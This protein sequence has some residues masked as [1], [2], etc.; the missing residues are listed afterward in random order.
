[1]F[2]GSFDNT[3]WGKMAV[4]N[5]SKCRQEDMLGKQSVNLIVLV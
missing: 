2:L 3:L 5:I 1:M 4:Q